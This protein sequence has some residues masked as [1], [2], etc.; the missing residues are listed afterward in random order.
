[1]KVSVRLN[2]IA[3]TEDVSRETVPMMTYNEV[4]N[5]ALY[6]AEQQAEATPND[7]MLHATSLLKKQGSIFKQKTGTFTK[8]FSNN[9][10]NKYACMIIEPHFL[11][12]K[13]LFRHKILCF[14]LISI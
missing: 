7:T 1:M 2:D 8:H 12:I 10:L 3:D 14:V 4:L 9:S 11:I 13:N 5:A 6:Y